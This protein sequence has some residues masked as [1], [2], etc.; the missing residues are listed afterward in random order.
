MR[1]RRREPQNLT[2]RGGLHRVHEAARPR[3][4]KAAGPVGDGPV[5]ADTPVQ[6][7]LDMVTSPL[8][9]D[10]RENE[11]VG[12]A[13]CR[14]LAAIVLSCTMLSACAE[15][16]A[17]EGRSEPKCE[18]SALPVRA[19][20]LGDSYVEGV[21]SSSESESLPALLA[22]D[23]S[24]HLAADGQ[25]ATG[26]VAPGDDPGDMPYLDRVSASAL[27]ATDVL[28]VEGS[29]NDASYPAEEVLA[30]AQAISDGGCCD[31]PDAGS[32]NSST[33]YYTER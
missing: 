10:R 5:C 32:Y 16:A 25:G 20:L 12:W 14:L 28:I 15:V 6:G 27:E 7:Q 4:R 26:Y 30:A 3:G 11:T 18:G 21:G 23:L 8:V 9:R 24:W 19:L 33:S 31:R 17:C 2:L 13:A 29:I 22:Q 1:G